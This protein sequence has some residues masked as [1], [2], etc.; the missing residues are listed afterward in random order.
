LEAGGV[1]T[2]EAV[3]AGVAAVDFPV[4]LRMGGCKLGVS[5]E[6]A[7]VDLASFAGT[8]REAAVTLVEAGAGEAFPDPFAAG[9]VVAAA[10]EG[11]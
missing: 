8:A 9:L 4:F 3:E 10:V 5:P 6:E 11:V 7:R 2:G 1:E